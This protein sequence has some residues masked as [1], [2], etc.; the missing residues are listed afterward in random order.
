[1]ILKNQELLHMSVKRNPVLV[2]GFF[3]YIKRSELHINKRT[4]QCRRP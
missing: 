2:A 3:C 1:M 4:G